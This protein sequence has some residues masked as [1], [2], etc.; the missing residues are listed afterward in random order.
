MNNLNSGKLINFA[1][2]ILSLI[3]G[4]VLYLYPMKNIS[5]GYDTWWIFFIQS[6]TENLTF[7]IFYNHLGI[8]PGNIVSS[9]IALF[10]YFVLNSS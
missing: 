8:E 7:P 3:V 6:S 10:D 5:L 9:G 4:F 2:L 1:V